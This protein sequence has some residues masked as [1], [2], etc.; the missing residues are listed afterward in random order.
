MSFISYA[1]NFEDVML[2]RALKHI[3]NGFYIDVGANDPTIDSVTKAFYER[4]W[5]G[6]NIEPLESHYND[7]QGERPRDINL[8]CAAGETSGDIGIYECDKRGWATAA[9]S[10][11]DKLV[12]EGHEGVYHRVPLRTLSD[13]C[14]EY[15]SGEIHFLKIDVEGLEKHVI[16]GADFQK[17]RPWIVVVE[18]MKPNS[19]KEEYKQW[20]SLLVAASY[21]FAYADGLNRFY[22]ANERA[23]LLPAFKYPPNVFDGFALNIQHQAESRSQQAEVRAHQ[24]EAMAQQ[25]EMLLNSIYVSRSWRITAPLRWCGHQARMARQQGL[26]L[27]LKALI[28]KNLRILAGS[29]VALIRRFG[30]Y[31]SLRSFYFLCSG[32]QDPRNSPSEVGQ[33]AVSNAAIDQLS[34]R[35]R[36][37]YVDL[38]AAIAQRQKESR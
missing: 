29:G 17:F 26:S 28:K 11:A 34:S 36:R 8:Y 2:W 35:A 30:I 12:Q 19:T 4:G 37:I 31:D 38:K 21:Q 32:Q 9:Q 22:V 5:R 16:R 27:R 18:S 15:V 13:I 24:A 33:G 20:E 25:A 14:Q 1:Q 6:I 3:E 23:E 10:V 7:L